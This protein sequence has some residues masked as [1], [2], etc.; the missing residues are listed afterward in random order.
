MQTPGQPGKVRRHPGNSRALPPSLPKRPQVNAESPTG[1]DPHWGMGRPGGQGGGDTGRHGDILTLGRP[2]TAKG[3][4]SGAK[5][6]KIPK[7]CQYRICPIYPLYDHTVVYVR[8]MGIYPPYQPNAYISQMIN[9]YIL[10]S[11]QLLPYVLRQLQN[12]HFG[13]SGVAESKIHS[14]PVP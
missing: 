2:F 13:S 10:I 12:G 3:S 8:Y 1:L 9:V 7:V 14:G 5:R 11:S 6:T 4:V